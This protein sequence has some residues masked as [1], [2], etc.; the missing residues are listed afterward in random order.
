MFLVVNAGAKMRRTVF[1][2][3]LLAVVGGCA[4]PQSYQQAE[5]NRDTYTYQGRELSASRMS[6]DSI[7]QNRAEDLFV[8]LA[9]VQPEEFELRGSVVSRIN[10]GGIGNAG[11]ESHEAAAIAPPSAEK[12]ENNLFARANEPVSLLLNTQNSLTDNGWRRGEGGYIHLPSGFVCPNALS[13]VLENED[14][15]V[16]STLVLPIADIHVFN[17]QGTDTACDYVDANKAAYFTLFVS[18]WP[19]VTLADHYSSALQHIVDRFSVASETT[20]LSP[21]IDLG[22]NS[23]HQS[24]IEGDTLS[25]AF[26]LEPQDGI[27]AKTALWLNKTGDWHVKARATYV[28][29]MVGEEPQIMAAELLAT[30]FHAATLF[31][32]D[33]RINT[34]GGG[35]EVSY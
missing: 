28:V 9:G 22:A 30:V 13:M 29:N 14:T 33:K 12:T 8:E 4:T 31:S 2:V 17:D 20:L 32:V 11:I 15:N 6:F 27:N 24:T 18:N 5:L 10:I 23:Q 21:S 19:N 1:G 34:G 3:A 7:V 26:M 16:T 25:G 35:V